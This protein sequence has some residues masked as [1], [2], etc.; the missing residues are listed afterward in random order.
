MPG[1]SQHPQDLGAEAHPCHGGIRTSDRGTLAGF[2]MGFYLHVPA[3][4]VMCR[5]KTITFEVEKLF[6][7]CTCR[8]H[9]AVLHQA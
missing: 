6:G 3:R 8:E 7:G 9:P 4:A 2:F 5:E 1:V